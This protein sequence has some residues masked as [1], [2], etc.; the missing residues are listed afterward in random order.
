MYLLWSFSSYSTNYGTSGDII[1]DSD[2][3]T[4]MGG[5]SNTIGITGVISKLDGAVTYVMWL[6]LK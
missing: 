4:I 2:G 1:H 5:A 6:L 3:A